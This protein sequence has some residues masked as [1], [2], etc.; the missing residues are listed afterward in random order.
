M[1]KTKI[2]ENVIRQLLINS[3]GR[4]EYRGCNEHLF[5]DLITKNRFNFS[6][7]AHIVADSENGPR[8]D[9]SRSEKLKKDISNL[10]LLCDKHHRLIDKENVEGHP[11]SLLVEMKKEHE[12]RI[13]RLTAI[14]PE[15]HS[16][17]VTYF[18][19]IGEHTPNITFEQAANYL[20]PDFYPATSGLIELA[21]TNSP[22]KDND[23]TFW[24]TELQILQKNFHE[25]LQDLLRNKRIKH[26]SLFAL[27]PM[28]LLIKLGTLI[29]DIQNIEIHQPRRTPKTWNLSNDLIKEDYK[30]IRPKKSYKIVALNISLSATIDNKRIEK[31]LGKEISIYTIRIKEPFN[32]FL[33]SKYQ[34]YDFANHIRKLFDE[35]KLKY[36]EETKLHIFPAMPVALAIELGRV[37]MPKA[38]MPLV[39]YDQ[40]KKLNG[41]TKTIEIC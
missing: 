35:I 26:I 25:K 21:T 19:N 10:M 11:E 17:I 7:I 32:D 23:V 36:N 28:P 33:K 40:N 4:C 37:W 8:G 15:R 38:D 3:G 24:E 30:I 20:L 6:Y 16:H 41:F 27:A 1:S 5:K 22:I 9:R 12:D 2:P 39:I 18:V 13:E 14:Q 31:V 34:V 29:N